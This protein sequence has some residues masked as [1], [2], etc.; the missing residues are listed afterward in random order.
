MFEGHWVGEYWHTRQSAGVLVDAQANDTQRG[1]F[2]IDFDTGDVPRDR[3][4]VAGQ[5]W[6]SYRSGEAGPARFGLSLIDEAGDWWI[7]ASLMRVGA[8]LRN[9][10]LLPWDCRVDRPATAKSRSEPNE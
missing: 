5:P 4:V 9:I 10:E 2:G 7:A 6:A 8:A 1:W 3:F